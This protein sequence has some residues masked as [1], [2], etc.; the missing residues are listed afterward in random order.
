M[1]PLK[2]DDVGF[3]PGRFD[4]ALASAGIK[5]IEVMNDP[6]RRDGEDIDVIDRPPAHDLKTRFKPKVEKPRMYRV[7][8]HNDNA[9]PLAFVV[10][11]LKSVFHMD[12][13]Q[14]S[15]LM[16]KVHQ[17]GEGG[18]A[19]VAVYTFEIAETKVN[20]AMGLA[21]AKGHPLKFTMEPE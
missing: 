6:R 21:H 18:A 4:F 3:R 2:A 11:V 20:K 1:M 13:T 14:A 10:E 9:T 17:Q 19:T 16:Y 7:I 15:A 8:L 5:K 12:E